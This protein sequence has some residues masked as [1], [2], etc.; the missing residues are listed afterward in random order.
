VVKFIQQSLS[1]DISNTSSSSSN[2][3]SNKN[4][5]NVVYVHCVH[6]QSRSC[7]V[8]VAYLMHYALQINSID[9]ISNGDDHSTSNTDSDTESDN[10][11]KEVDK[12]KYNHKNK[13]SSSSTADFFSTIKD[14]VQLLHICYNKVMSSRPQMAI[15]PG[16][17][18]QLEI[19]RQMKSI[20]TSTSTLLPIQS[21]I[22]Q[23]S[24]D[25][26]ESGD[27]HCGNGDNHTNK[28]SIGMKKKKQSMIQSKSH[29]YF[30]SFRSK[31]E[32]YNTGTITSKFCPL[33]KTA[34]ATSQLTPPLPSSIIHTHHDKHEDRIKTYQCKNCHELLFTEFNIL[35]EWNE[36]YISSNLPISDY[37]KDSAGGMEYF[38]S[39]GNCSSSHNSSSNKSNHNKKINTNTNVNNR[40]Y[41]F[42]AALTQ[43]SKIY[44][45]EP[46]EWME[47]MLRNDTA[48]T[49]TSSIRNTLQD[50]ICN[51]S[52]HG[53]LHCHECST[54]IG[55]WDFLNK[56]DLP[57]A[58]IILKNK[59]HER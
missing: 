56:K 57:T 49:S 45:I 22:E 30:R 50:T 15:N 46:M 25:G 35:Y 54:Q 9:F 41:A 55:Y 19:F 23:V 1:C 21:T 2:S 48:G 42:E 52:S 32:F 8:C 3:A 51:Y 4:K 28:N 27:V 38:N 26:K 16:F 6:G 10:M 33:D 47:R 11:N 29:A 59:V 12:R 39:S 5:K 18:K 31:A 44:K 20:S 43:S 17:V 40:N 58:I 14:N 24:K 37:W 53:N 34:T 36:E 7:T 13:T